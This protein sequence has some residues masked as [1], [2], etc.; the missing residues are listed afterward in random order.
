MFENAKTHI[1]YVNRF[2]GVHM[3]HL[4]DFHQEVLEFEQHS[5]YHLEWEQKNELLQVKEETKQQ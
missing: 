2:P 1:L 5:I 3:P 4:I